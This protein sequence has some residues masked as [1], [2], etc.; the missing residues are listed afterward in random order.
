VIGGFATLTLLT[1][2]TRLWMKSAST[3]GHL[4]PAKGMGRKNRAYG[5]VFRNAM[6]DVIASLA[7]VLVSLSTEALLIELSSPSD[8]SW[9]TGL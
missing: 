6:L 5:H 2:K 4:P 3:R 7:G 8:A 9:A 1:K